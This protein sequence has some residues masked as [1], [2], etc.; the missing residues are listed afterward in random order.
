MSVNNLSYY[1]QRVVDSQGL[2][3]KMMITALRNYINN[4]PITQILNEIDEIYTSAQLKAMWEAGLNTTLQDA[5][6]KRLEKLRTR[7]D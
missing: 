4:T 6:M 5:V 1:S 2:I 7:R 3:H